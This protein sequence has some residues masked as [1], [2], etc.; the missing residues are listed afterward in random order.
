MVVTPTIETFLTA[1]FF[2][3]YHY[4]KLHKVFSKFYRRHSELIGD[5][6]AG[7]KKSATVFYGDAVYK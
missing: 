2:Q 3:R 1:K 5:H 7:L 6:I 4:H